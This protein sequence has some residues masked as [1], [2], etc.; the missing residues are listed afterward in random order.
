MCALKW[1]ASQSCGGNTASGSPHSGV[2]S[3]T[4]PPAAPPA[5][6]T[7]RSPTRPPPGAPPSPRT[8]GGT[9]GSLR[10]Q[11][12]TATPSARVRRMTK[13]PPPAALNGAPYEAALEK[14]TPQ[15]WFEFTRASQFV[16]VVSLKRW[17]TVNGGMKHAD[18]GGRTRIESAAEACRSFP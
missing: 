16:E 10:D 13:K 4:F 6:P 15:P 11:N 2:D 3:I 7:T 14:E 12:Q 18:E 9:F 8:S 5:T 17:A 1:S